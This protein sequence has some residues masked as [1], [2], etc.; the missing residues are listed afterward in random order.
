MRWSRRKR[1]DRG[2]FSRQSFRARCVAGGLVHRRR[3]R[4]VRRVPPDLIEMYA[5]R[6]LRGDHVPGRRASPTARWCSPR[7]GWGNDMRGR[8]LER[9]H[10]GG[11]GC[12]RSWDSC[13]RGRKPE[14]SCT[15]R[16]RCTDWEGKSRGAAAWSSRSIFVGNAGT[17]A[18]SHGRWFALGTALSHR[19]SAADAERPQAALFLRCG[20]LGTGSIQRTT[21]CGILFMGGSGS[22]VAGAVSPGREFSICVCVVVSGKKR[23]WRIEMTGR[24][25]GREG[26]DFGQIAGRTAR[27]RR[28]ALRCDDLRFAE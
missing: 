23:G 25:G 17:A 12:C 14:E 5:T 10:A 16:S 7:G 26:R 6:K 1:S 3:I 22:R 21:G 11:G 4:R 8:A 13:E 15:G 9:R 20:I 28:V 19:T 18:G 2:V 27:S 24:Q